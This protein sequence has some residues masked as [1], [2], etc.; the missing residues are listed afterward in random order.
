MLL[1]LKRGMGYAR[2]RVALP[3]FGARGLHAIRTQMNG[4]ATAPLTALT[5]FVL[6]FATADAGTEFVPAIFNTTRVNGN[7]SSDFPEGEKPS[8]LLDPRES[9]PV[10]GGTNCT[11]HSL[12]TD[13]LFKFVD[14]VDIVCR[15]KKGRSV[16]DPHPIERVMRRA[17]KSFPSIYNKIVW[18]FERAFVPDSRVCIL[19]CESVERWESSETYKKPAN[20]LRTL[21]DSCFQTALRTLE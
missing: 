14:V 1:K 8:P 18:L 21:P 10:P 15:T 9:F 7:V 2:A 5:I 17:K 12:I 6:L 4:R 13:S 3:N 11:E 19:Y 20:L 16:T